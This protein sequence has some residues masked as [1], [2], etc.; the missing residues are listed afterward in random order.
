M[1]ASTLA[2]LSLLGLAN[3][4][5]KASLNAAAACPGTIAAGD[6]SPSSLVHV[7]SD[8]KEKKHGTTTTGAIKPKTMCSWFSFDAPKTTQKNSLCLLTFLFPDPTI[9]NFE[10]YEFSGPGNFSVRAFYPTDDDNLVEGGMTWDTQP[11][12]TGAS[13]QELKTK[14]LPNGSYT[15]S[16]GECTKVSR[17]SK[18]FVRLCSDD[19]QFV[20]PQTS[21]GQCPVGLYLLVFPKTSDAPPAPGGRPTAAASPPRSSPATPASPGLPASPGS[22]GPRFTGGVG[23]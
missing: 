14:I 4:L 21:A 18:L 3:A 9:M 10:K 11:Q 5:P 15:I 16:A 22:P 8:D 20:F 1:R 23:F 13:I 19:T 17:G 7:T 12:G 2:C 6:V